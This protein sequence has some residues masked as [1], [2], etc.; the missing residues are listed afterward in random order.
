MSCI[1]RKLNTIPGPYRITPASCVEL[2]IRVC[3]QR[4]LADLLIDGLTEEQLVFDTACQLTSW[5]GTILG[6]S[7]ADLYVHIQAGA[8][9]YR[10]VTLQLVEKLSLE[11]MTVGISGQ[12]PVCRSA[13]WRLQ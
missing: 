12:S 9:C 13:S 1:S 2:N 10:G 11:G 8:T 7:S 4:Y 5:A 6:T 3:G